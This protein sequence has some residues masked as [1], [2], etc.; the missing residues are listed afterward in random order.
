MR[1]DEALI[2][3]KA[4]RGDHATLDVLF[5]VQKPAFGQA[6]VLVRVRT[7]GVSTHTSQKPTLE[8]VA[9]ECTVDETMTD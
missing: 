5:R 9:V 4:Q 1:T 7:A 6:G 3:V 2:T 8:S